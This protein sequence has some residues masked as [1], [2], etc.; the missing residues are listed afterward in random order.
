LQG[1]ILQII[2]I[3]VHFAKKIILVPDKHRKLFSQG[4]SVLLKRKLSENF[5]H[6]KIFTYT[7][8]SI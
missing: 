7:Y 8:S 1:G 5:P 4:A 6:T 2:G 3:G